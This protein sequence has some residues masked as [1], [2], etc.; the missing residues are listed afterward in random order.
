MISEGG[1][2]SSSSPRRAV[3][4]GVVSLPRDRQILQLEHQVADLV[5]QAYGLTPEDIDWM[6]RTAPPRMPIQRNTQPEL[7]D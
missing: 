3:S 7:G 6:W 1:C 2:R 4:N 5:N